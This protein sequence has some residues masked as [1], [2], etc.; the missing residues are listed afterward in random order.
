MPSYQYPEDTV[1]WRR[2]PTGLP[3]VRLYR[4]PKGWRAEIIQLDE[5]PITWR[6]FKKLQWWARETK[7]EE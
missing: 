4:P 3:D 5:H 7:S 6:P 1:R 2:V